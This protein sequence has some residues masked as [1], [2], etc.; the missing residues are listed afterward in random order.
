MFL[1][2]WDIV[3]DLKTQRS[4]PEVCV[5]LE[6][7][8]IDS[9]HVWETNM[10]TPLN[11]EYVG[12]FNINIEEG[13]TEKKIPDLVKSEDQKGLQISISTEKARARI[14]PFISSSSFLFILL[15]NNIIAYFVTSYNIAAQQNNKKRNEQRYPCSGSYLFPLRILP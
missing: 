13:F 3:Q 15:S 6:D 11:F 9:L 10:S 2:G 1:L 12:I 5:K 4:I 8:S 7:T 14:S